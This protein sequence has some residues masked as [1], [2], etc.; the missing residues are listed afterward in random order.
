MK[1][2]I[3][4]VVALLAGA[5]AVHSQGTVSF[6]NYT[7]LNNPGQSY[8]YVSLGTTK[9]G[10]QS[11]GPAAT[12]ANYASEVADGDDWSVALYG[13]AGSGVPASGL[14]PLNTLLTGGVPLVANIA[15]G[16]ASDSLVGTWYSG[17]SGVIPNTPNGDGSAA[18]VQVYAWYNDGGVLTSYSAAQA[19]GVPT[20]FSLTGN[21]TTGGPQSGLPPAFPAALPNGLGNI[22]LSST[23]VIPEPS[24]IALGVMGASAF[25]MR[26]R[27]KQ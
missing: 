24:T 14:S 1:K 15:D 5:F 9:L 4:G 22:T 27:K 17:A 6:G 25:L 13:A 3:T 11:T 26:L 2:S 7:A 23:S 21:V 18:T 20:G 19:A 16:T 12:T 10:G 8:I